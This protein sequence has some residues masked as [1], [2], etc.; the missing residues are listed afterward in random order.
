MQKLIDAAKA[1][2][3]WAIRELLD[4]CL[5]KAKR[6]DVVPLHRQAAGALRDTRPAFAA[7]SERIFKTMPTTVTLR[8]DLARARKKWIEEAEDTEEKQ[9]REDSHFLAAKDGEGRVVDLHSLRTTLGTNLA[10]QG[11]T[12]QMAQRIMRHSDYR[13]TLAYY[14]V[15]GLVDTA[16]AINTL[17]DIAVHVEPAAARATGTDGRA[18]PGTARRTQN[19][20]PSRAKMQFTSRSQESESAGRRDS[21]DLGDTPLSMDMDRAASSSNTKRAMGFEPTTTS[22]E[23]WSS[24][25]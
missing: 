14:T 20:A 5:G 3:A 15:L 22:L 10:L 17:P 18:A 19:D 13:T 24:S 7:P 6:E 9:H 16:K 25:H 8:K 11:V 12:P 23:G 4:R 2:K 1:G 21:K